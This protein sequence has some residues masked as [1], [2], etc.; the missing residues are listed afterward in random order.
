MKFEGGRY[1]HKVRYAA[2]GGSG[3]SAIAA[4]AGLPAFERLPPL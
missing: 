3:R 4:T 2:E 1:C